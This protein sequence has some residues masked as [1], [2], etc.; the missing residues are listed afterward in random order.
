MTNNLIL[1]SKFIHI[2]SKNRHNGEINN[3][4]V[5][6][7]SRMF[8]TNFYATYYK[9]NLQEINL[10]YSWYNINEFNSKFS[11][12]SGQVEI[13]LRL[14]EGNYNVNMLLEALN[15]ALELTYTVSYNNLKNTLIFSAKDPLYS[16]TCVSIGWMLGLDDGIT[17]NG[18]FESLKPITMQYADVLYLHSS[19][20]RLNDSVDNLEQDKFL[21]STIIATI[22]ITNNIYDNIHYKPHQGPNEGVYMAIKNFDALTF[23]ITT[24]NGPL[25]LNHDY[26]M[27]IRL[28][29]YRYPVKTIKRY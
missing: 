8:N 14:Q 22:P 25:K 4:T 27:T 12:S 16:F 1:G 13:L 15:S 6:F 28:E 3:F 11:T 2:D 29:H 10:K 24:N 7:P 21:Q 9:L 26:N 17:Y 18:D 19:C 20:P 5:N 23:W